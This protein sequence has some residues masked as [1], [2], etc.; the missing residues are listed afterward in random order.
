[1]PERQRAGA[2]RRAVGVALEQTELYR[3]PRQEARTMFDEVRDAVAGWRNEAKKL[4]LPS[5]E[6]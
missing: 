3:L 6:V 1:M 5:V 2:A 4:K